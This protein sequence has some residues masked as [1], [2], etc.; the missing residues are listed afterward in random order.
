MARNKERKNDKTNK[1]WILASSG[2]AVIAGRTGRSIVARGRPI[3]TLV[4]DKSLGMMR[5]V[6]KIVFR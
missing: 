2:A 6:E 4:Y 1:T 3:L 5:A